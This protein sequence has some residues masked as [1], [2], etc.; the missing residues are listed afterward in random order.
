M[1]LEPDDTC[2]QNV[3]IISMKCSNLNVVYMNFFIHTLMA[4]VAVQGANWI[5]SNVGFSILL[6]DTMTCS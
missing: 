3:D 2:W 4:E 1:K 5:G 6:K